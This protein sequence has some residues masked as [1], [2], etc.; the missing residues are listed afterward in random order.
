LAGQG[1]RIVERNWRTRFGELDLIGWSG[2]TLV[3]VE[4]RTRASGGLG[5][6][7]ESVGPAKQRQ[8]RLMA[9]QFLQQHAPNAAARIDVVTVRLGAVGP[10]SVDHIVGA[11]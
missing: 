4:V 6:A 11:V 2:D 8:L 9:E 10:P 7:A 5:T 3:F 1:Y